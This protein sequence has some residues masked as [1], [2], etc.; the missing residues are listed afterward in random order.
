MG[1][2]MFVLG[3]DGG[4]TKTTAVVADENGTVYMEV[5]TGGSNP[6]TLSKTGFEDVING[7]LNQLRIQNEEVYMQIKVCFAGMAGV[8]ESNR[9]KEVEELIGRS[10]P[11]GTKI[12]V[13]NDAF[14]ALFSGTL[15]SP[16]I[17]Q[18]SGTGAIT[19]GMNSVGKTERVGGWGYLFDDFGSGFDLGNKALQAVFKEYDGRGKATMLTDV[20][21]SY[22]DV[23]RVPDIIEKI[24]GYIHPRTVI[25]PLSRL[26][27]DAAIHDDAI[28]KEIIE[29]ACKDIYSSISACHQKL[30]SVDD[31]IPVILSGGVFSNNNLFM[32]QLKI[33]AQPEL[34]NIVFSSTKTA[35]VGGAIAA[36]LGR[37]KKQLN[38]QFIDTFN[39]QFKKGAK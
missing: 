11:K 9:H 28:A 22:F 24:Y 10:F 33:L 37:M 12:F 2:S 27:V 38:P 25:A 13:E 35:P 26:V 8:G 23:K 6:N 3:I 7:L 19:V 4:G 29:G 17:V 16:G 21:S 31:S 34:P 14:N 20:I 15:G 36:G 5:E 32:E 39:K 1:R 30:F 18:I